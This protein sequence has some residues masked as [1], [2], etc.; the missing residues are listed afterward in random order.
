M[1]FESREKHIIIDDDDEIEDEQVDEPLVP[2]FSSKAKEKVLSD[3]D[4][5]DDQEDINVELEATVTGVTQTTA[6]K[7][8]LL[9]IIVE[10]TAEELVATTFAPTAPQQTPTKSLT[11]APRGSR[12]CKGAQISGGATTLEEPKH[13][14]TRPTQPKATVPLGIPPISPI[15]S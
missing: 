12:K 7:K 10:I 14:Q 6:E 4:S 9:G 15:P 8:S 1:P 3:D 2:V 5:E 13:K 11:I